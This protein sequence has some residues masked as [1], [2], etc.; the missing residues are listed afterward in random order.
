MSTSLIKCAVFRGPP[1]IFAFNC[2]HIINLF[3]YSVHSSGCAGGGVLSRCQRVSGAQQPSLGR[4]R[5]NSSIDDEAGRSCR[6]LRWWH[7]HRTRLAGEDI[8]REGGEGGGRFP[9]KGEEARRSRD[10]SIYSTHTG[11]LGPHTPTGTGKRTDA[12]RANQMI[13][14]N[15]KEHTCPT[16]ETLASL[17][18]VQRGL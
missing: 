6:A 3:I 10:N 12:I 11:G 14:T 1:D 17:Q 5:H 7:A 2:V 16:R 9:M 18:A 13:Q 4:A 15:G 8:E